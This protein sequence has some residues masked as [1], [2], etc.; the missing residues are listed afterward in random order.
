[1]RARLKDETIISLAQYAARCNLQLVTAADFNAKLRER[2]LPKEATVQK[3]CRASHDE[4]EVREA[5]DAMWES[6]GKP[7]AS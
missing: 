3:V 1:L 6:P 2:D 7:A 5:L 4:R